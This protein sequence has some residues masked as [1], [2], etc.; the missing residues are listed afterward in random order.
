MFPT[1]DQTKLTKVNPCLFYSTLVS[2]PFGAFPALPTLDVHYCSQI[3]LVCKENMV[4]SLLKAAS[5]LE[6]F[7]RESEY[8]CAVMVK[9]MKSTFYAYDIEAPI[10]PNPVP[11]TAYPLDFDAPESKDFIPYNCIISCILYCLQLLLDINKLMKLFLFEKLRYLSTMGT[12]SSRSIKLCCKV[13][14]I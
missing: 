3:K 12:T 6:Q 11:L 10:L 1:T 8:S 13:I 4:M 2:C 14:F 5:E 7:A 9:L